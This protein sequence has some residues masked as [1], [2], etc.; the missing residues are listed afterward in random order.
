[1]KIVVVGVGAW[2]KN[3][4][5]TLAELRGEKLVDEVFVCDSDSERAMA[6]AKEFDC[7]AVSFDDV[8]KGQ[9]DGVVVA[10]PSPTHYSL[11]KDVMSSGKEVLVEKPLAM[12]FEDSM[13]LVKQA[14][15]QKRLLMVGHEF[16]FHPGI[17]T[18]TKMLHA[19]EFGKIIML[20]A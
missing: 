11:A 12:S 6:L 13:Q 15:E 2:G 5:K 10:T 4:V 8:K 19:G 17:Q 20:S 16:R 14:E 7:V 9:F 18:L 3:H 1:M